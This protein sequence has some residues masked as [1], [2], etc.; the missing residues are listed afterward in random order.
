M[1]EL[2]FTEEIFFFNISEFLFWPEIVKDWSYFS[3][4]DFQKNET[5]LFSYAEEE[6]AVF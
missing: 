2:T 3:W 4:L 1:Q 5:N 6:R